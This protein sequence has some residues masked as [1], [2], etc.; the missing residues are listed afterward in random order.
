MIYIFKL[1]NEDAA[2]AVKMESSYL[3]ERRSEDGLNESLLYDEEYQILFRD[4]FLQARAKI[5]E[6]TLAYSKNIEMTVEY[7]EINNMDSEK[8]FLL[9][10]SMPDTFIKQMVEP[11]TVRIKEYII[12]NIMYRWLETKLPQEAAVYFNRANDAL[13]DVKRMLEMRTV[14]TR[15]TGRYY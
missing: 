15:R 13:K 10:L 8:D 11:I 9:Y 12:S 1:S 5:I 3:A 4:H 2:K 7:F 6:A 14:N